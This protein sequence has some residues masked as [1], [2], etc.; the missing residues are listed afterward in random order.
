[1]TF[2]SVETCRQ[3]RAHEVGGEARPDDLRAETED[4]HVVVLDSLVGGVDVVADGCPNPGDLARGNRRADAGAADEHAALGLAVLD[5]GAELGGLDGIVDPHRVGVGAEVH[6]LVSGTAQR[7]EE[8]VPEM[9]ASVVERHGNFH[10][11]D[12]T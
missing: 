6:D 12:R 11:T 10:A 7:L 4:V 2:F 3:K 5:R 8:L 9:D 1:M